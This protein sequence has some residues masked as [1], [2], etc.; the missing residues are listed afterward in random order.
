MNV[1]S[2]ISEA[3]AAIK[4][5]EGRKRLTAKKL[6]ELKN[7][8]L[9][10]FDSNEL[11][12]EEFCFKTKKK[13]LNERVAGVDSGFA[14]KRMHS[15]DII[16]V[17]TVGAIFDF[18]KNKL[19]K[20]QYHPAPSQFPIPFIS[21]NVL[22]NDEF[23]CN[24]SLLRL[25]E[26]IECAKKIIS[27]FKP[28]FC[29]LDGSI[30]PQHADKPRADSKLCSSYKQLTELYEQ[31]YQT[32]EKNSCSLIATVE[33]SRGSRFRSIM[34]KEILEKEKIVE[35]SALENYFDSSLLG[36]ILE[37]NERSF[38]FNYST[39]AKEHPILNDFTKKWAERVK[40]FYL[41]PTEYDR[42]L[43]IEFLHNGRNITEYCNEIAS[44]SLTLSSLHKEYAFPSVLIEA[45][46]RARLKS[47]EIEILFNKIA[48]KLGRENAYLALRR[49]IRPF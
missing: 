46:L 23:Q 38:C 17:K 31:L 34:Q 14:G 16:L 27:D 33:D 7:A 36:Y 42:P 11:L 39:S 44:V 1:N 41:K 32:A 6:A 18:E 15:I 43:R 40:V 3:V 49:E 47:N 4:E 30:I 2:L 29:F 13:E 22:E 45:D 19:K 20:A 5:A 12:E 8:S 9:K 21:S 35:G 10:K 37:K 26:E 48:D 24:K 28:K 25:K